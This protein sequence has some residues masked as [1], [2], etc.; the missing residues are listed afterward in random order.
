[1]Q[2]IDSMTSFDGRGRP[3]A[4]HSAWRGSVAR[5][6]FTICLFCVGC[7]AVRPTGKPEAAVQEGGQQDAGPAGPVV[8]APPKARALT[9]VP[10][11]K[12]GKVSGEFDAAQ[13]RTARELV[14]D[15]GEDWVPYIFSE[16]SAPGEQPRSEE[17][18]VGK[19]CRSRWSPYH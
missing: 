7:A 12:D 6:T 19:E 5:L 3:A 15:L 4:H 18:R 2:R 14:I 17:R 13:A 8:A 10:L 9:P 1:M 11:W 16:R